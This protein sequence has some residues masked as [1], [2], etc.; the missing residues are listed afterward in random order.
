MTTIK[1]DP[2]TN[3]IHGGIKRGIQVTIENRCY[4]SA[5]NLILSGIDTMAYLSMPASQQ[6]VKQK[7]FVAWAERYI[8]F[9]CK[10]QLTGLD[11]YGARCAML[12]TYG[13]RSKLSRE[14][15]CRMIC[16]MDKGIPE[17]RSK[18][19]LKDLVIVSVSAL[20]DAFF[21]GIDNFLVDLFSNK[22]KAAMA[23]ER[24]TELMQEHNREDLI[25]RRCSG[26]Q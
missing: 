8:K 22:E 5:T 14:G 11:L 3:A 25:T 26:R 20:A 18:P 16:Y 15:K 4:G 1:N 7:D 23:E 9:P 2:I 19:H 10:E 12:H 6:D 17:I 21:C 24:L 13:T